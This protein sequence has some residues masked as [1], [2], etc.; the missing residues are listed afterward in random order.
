MDI[1][2]GQVF[3]GF[4]GLTEKQKQDLIDALNDYYKQPA[5]VQRQ[6]KEYYTKRADLGPLASNICQY[7]G[8]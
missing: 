2:T 7:C 3:K 8:R 1:Q 4:L 6:I 5:N